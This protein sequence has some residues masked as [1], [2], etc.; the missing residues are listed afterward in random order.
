M[1][2]RYVDIYFSDF[3]FYLSSSLSAFYVAPFCTYLKFLFYFYFSFS[4]CFSLF[5]RFLSHFSDNF[6]LPF[7][8]FFPAQIANEIAGGGGSYRNIRNICVGSSSMVLKHVCKHQFYASICFN[9]TYDIIH[10]LMYICNFVLP[11]IV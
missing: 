5:F 10:I 1:Y 8:L 3:N 2:L 4:G 6:H 11:D 7:F 9:I